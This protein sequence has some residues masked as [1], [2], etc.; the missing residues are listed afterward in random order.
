M[1]GADPAAAV[2][3]ATNGLESVKKTH[4][5]APVSTGHPGPAVAGSGGDICRTP[6]ATGFGRYGARPFLDS[7]RMT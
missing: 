2:R 7:D 6:G 3:N 1:T 5:V 4:Q